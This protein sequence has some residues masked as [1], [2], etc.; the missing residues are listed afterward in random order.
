M[1]ISKFETKNTDPSISKV[2]LPK[3]GEENNG[4]SCIISTLCRY[5]PYSA[6]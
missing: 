2:G 3:S 5:I 4:Y 1:P 6:L